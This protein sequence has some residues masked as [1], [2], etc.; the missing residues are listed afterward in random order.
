MTTTTTT[1]HAASRAGRGHYDELIKIVREAEL[2]QGTGSILSWDREVMMPEGGLDFRSKQASLIARLHHEMLT[3][4]RVGELIAACEADDDLTADPR[5]VEAVNIRE[6]RREYDRA[7]KLPSSLV[8]EEYE[9]GSYAQHEWA[10][11]RKNSDFKHFRPWLEK[12]VNLLKRK[13]EC[14][15]WAE[16]GEPWDALAEDYEPG[17]TAAEVMR[18]FTPLRDQLQKLLDDLSGSANPPSNVFNETPL[19]TEQQEQFVRFVAESIGFDFNRGRLDRSTHP[20]CS[21]THPGDVRL[22]T[23][24]HEM[25]VNDALGSTMHEAGHGIY[26]QGLPGEHWGTPMGA[27]VSL[28]IHESQSRMWEN[29]VGRSEHFWKWLY[30]RMGEFFGD[31]VK[32][33]TFEDVYG[34]A[35]IVKP[36][37]IR[38]E[39]DEATYNMHIMVR[40]EIERALMNGDL[41]IADIPGVWN[42]RYKEYLGIDV[43]DDRRGC[44]QDIHW[45]MLSIGYFPTYTLGNLYCAQFFEKALQEIPDLHEQFAR[46]E[47]SALK[48]WLNENIHAHGKRYRAAALCEHVTGKPLSAE[49]LMRHLEGKLRPLYRV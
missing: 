22:T 19:P 14:Y 20:F 5:Q 44:L 37:F 36:D 29:Q 49:P 8:A 45:S 30:P 10:K 47:F 1:T 21:G 6:I 31:A 17:C 15:G 3:S 18:V 39:A 33:L 48:K 11:A 41:A 27:S 12:V 40:F 34:G 32:S 28:G 35:N 4:E 16:D 43:P 9:L 2:L 25:N 46:G 23:R 13:A 38:V 26:E 42:E 24:F 7:T